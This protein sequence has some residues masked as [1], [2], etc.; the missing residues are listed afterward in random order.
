MRRGAVG[1][2]G[3][4]HLQHTQIDP[5]LQN[6]AADLVGA[7]PLRAAVTLRTHGVEPLVAV[8]LPALSK[9]VWKW[10]DIWVGEARED[11][12]AAL[13]S[14]RSAKAVRPPRPITLP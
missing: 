7:D 5:Q 6:L 9:E 3:D 13:T 4:L 12:A 10:L 11:T 14:V 8:Q 1:T 2:A